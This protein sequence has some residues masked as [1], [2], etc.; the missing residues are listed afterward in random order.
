M[1]TQQLW[2]HFLQR[3]LERVARAAVDGAKK[4]NEAK[5]RGKAG[6]CATS[7]MQQQQTDF[8]LARSMTLEPTEPALV[9][10]S[11]SHK[12][13][14]SEVLLFECLC[15]MQLFLKNPQRVISCV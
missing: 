10:A 5:G 3:R 7:R 12:N 11:V 4:G 1:L 9:G 14:P 13:F 15:S 8:E 6:P 2:R